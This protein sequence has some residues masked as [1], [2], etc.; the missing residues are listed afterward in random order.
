LKNQMLD[1]ITS[2][3]STWNQPLDSEHQL[4]LSTNQWSS[5]IL[6]FNTSK[7]FIMSKSPSSAPWQFPGVYFPLLCC[8]SWDSSEAAAPPCS[9]VASNN[10][11]LVSMLLLSRSLQRTV[12]AISGQSML[13]FFTPSFI[14]N[15]YLV[16]GK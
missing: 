7:S 13:K 10:N 11:S 16:N 5:W 14:P 2:S 3:M 15:H 6:S 9:I 4:E 8:S 1:T 12:D